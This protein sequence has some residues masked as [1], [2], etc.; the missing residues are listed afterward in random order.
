MDFQTSNVGVQKASIENLAQ[1]THRIDH[2][3]VGEVSEGG[4]GEAI[5]NIKVAEET[6]TAGKNRRA[7]AAIEDEELKE[8]T[9]E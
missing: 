7:G 5:V 8:A 6:D 1:E 2:V 3:G 9:V 4:N